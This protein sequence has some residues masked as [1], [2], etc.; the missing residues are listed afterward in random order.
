MSK[1]GFLYVGMGK[2]YRM[3]AEI[4]ARSLKQYTKYPICIVTEDSNY[5]S[6]YFDI[7]I[8]ANLVTDFYGKIICA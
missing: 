5:K 2:K 1:N 8:V 4:S 7:I 6:E 3:E